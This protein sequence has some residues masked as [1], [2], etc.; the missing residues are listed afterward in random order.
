LALLKE[1][2]FA[3]N[4]HFFG[5]EGRCGAPTLFDAAY[6]LNL[7]LTAGSLMLAGKTGM[8]AGLKNLETGM[9]P[10]A[11]PL[12]ALM[13]IERRHGHD[14]FVIEKALTELDAPAFQFFVS[15]R[16]EWARSDR[17]TSPGPRQLW[18]PAALQLPI[19]VA[20]NRG[21]QGLGFTC[22]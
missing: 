13:N 4:H 15:R 16:N 9:L 8:M 20:L 22:A 17:F 10:V 21:Y 1:F 14:E 18:G 2:Q 6:T 3:S 12:T 7:G 5:Y 19:S 11:I